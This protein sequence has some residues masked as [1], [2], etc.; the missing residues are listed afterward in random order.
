MPKR[1]LKQIGRIKEDKIMIQD[2]IAQANEHVVKVNKLCKELEDMEVVVEVAE[3]SEVALYQQG[4][5]TTYLTTVLSPETMDGLK[6]AINKSLAGTKAAKE[7]ELEKLMGVRKPAIVNPDFEAAVQDMVDS[8]RKEPLLKTFPEPVVPVPAPDHPKL[9]VDA[10]R[11]MYLEEGKTLTETAAFFGVKK[12]MLNSFIG[13][14]HLTRTN[15]KKDD[16]F[17]DA[18]VESRKK[19]PYIEANKM[20]KDEFKKQMLKN[21]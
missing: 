16:G 12:T 8:A 11:K 6:Q 20:T 10:V 4:A 2:L 5:G 21:Q 18:E 17:K 1:F 19:D 13:R 14:N 9:T 3:D 7:L 15:Y